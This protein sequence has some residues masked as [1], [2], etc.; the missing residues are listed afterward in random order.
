MLKIGRGV[1]SGEVHTMS[2]FN[3]SSIIYYSAVLECHLPVVLGY[4]ITFVCFMVGKVGSTLNSS[5][6][7]SLRYCYLEW[8]LLLCFVVNFKVSVFRRR[9]KSFR[10]IWLQLEEVRQYLHGF[11]SIDKYVV[12]NMFVVLLLSFYVGYFSDSHEVFRKTVQYHF[13]SFVSTG[14]PWR[15]F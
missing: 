12:Y 9:I 15:N 3:V 5:V 2:E 6:L 13:Q 7:H 14:R 11:V 10:P 1:V 4:Y 8:I